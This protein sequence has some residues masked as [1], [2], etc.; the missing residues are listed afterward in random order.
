VKDVASGLD[1]RKT[2][3]DTKINTTGNGKMGFPSTEA[4]WKSSYGRGKHIQFSF[5]FRGLR[6]PFSIQVENCNFFFPFEMGSP[7]VALAAFYLTNSS[8]CFASDSSSWDFEHLPPC[9]HS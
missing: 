6:G 8:D 5:P 1:M 3:W 4:L 2:Q 9:I 7:C